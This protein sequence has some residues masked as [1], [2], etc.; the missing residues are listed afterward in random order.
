MNCPP[1]S[2]STAVLRVDAP[3]AL[4]CTGDRRS[5]VWIWATVSCQQ[6]VP[7]FST[8][9]GYL[10]CAEPGAHPRGSGE[11][12]SV[13]PLSRV[14]PLF[15]I[16]L[17]AQGFAPP[18]PL[19]LSSS[20]FTLRRATPPPDPASGL[21]LPTSEKEGLIWNLAKRARGWGGEG[22]GVEVGWG[23][24]LPVEIFAEYFHGPMDCWGR[25]HQGRVPVNQACLNPGSRL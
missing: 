8:A 22:V 1:L 15:P 13:P 23:W 19:F 16:R 4:Q 9:R 21:S 20:A 17:G 25:T 2:H 12:R 3:A 7:R 5:P 18:Q 10:F 24:G 14:W 11:A 6:A